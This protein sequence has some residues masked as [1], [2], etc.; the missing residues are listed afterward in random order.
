M[1]DDVCQCARCQADLAQIRDIL[2]D[3]DLIAV[4]KRDLQAAIANL[5]GG[6]PERDV[7]NR[8]ETLLESA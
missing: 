4:P 5:G 1:C 8:L 2:R 7:R 6:K 3:F